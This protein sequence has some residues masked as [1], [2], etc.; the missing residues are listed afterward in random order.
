M[1]VSKLPSAQQTFEIYENQN[2]ITGALTSL[3]N[4]MTTKHKPRKP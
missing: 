2:V 3:Y 4:N 1:D